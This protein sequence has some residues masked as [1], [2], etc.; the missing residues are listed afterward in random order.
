M[1]KS[2]LV[3]NLK[4]L[5]IIIN[6]YDCIGIGSEFCH[7]ILPH[8]LDEIDDNIIKILKRKK[9]LIYTPLLTDP[10][11][12]SFVKKLARF[13]QKLDDIEIMLNDFGLLNY[14]NYNFPHIKKGISRPLSIDLVRMN[15]KE[16]YKFVKEYKI[17]SIET[18]EIDFL[19]KFKNRNF[20]IYLRI[21]LKFIGLSR[22][23]PYERK[24][25][26]SCSYKCL[27][28]CEELQV[29]DCNAKLILFENCY[30]K[31]MKII[32]YK[33]L[34]F[35]MIIETISSSFKWK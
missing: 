21:P 3:N 17:S 15:N 6:K 25:T 7:N 1:K 22:F 29:K 11:F 27:S 4:D 13:M 5:K 8:L 33:K 30:F 34:D 32:N 9:V 18:D 26:Y 14:L 2:V 24:I 23:C 16:V 28:F 20:K 31:K 12:E 35:D 10:I 19:P